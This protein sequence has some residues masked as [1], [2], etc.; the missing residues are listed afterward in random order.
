MC[1]V[2]WESSRFHSLAAGIKEVRQSQFPMALHAG[3][4]SFCAETFV[5]AAATFHIPISCTVAA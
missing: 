5:L 4:P 2:L 1:E 3:L